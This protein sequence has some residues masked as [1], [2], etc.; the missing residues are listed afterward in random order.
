MSDHL[1]AC[2]FCGQPPQPKEL[3][4][5]GHLI[6]CP[7][8]GAEGPVSDNPRL[9]VQAWNRRAQPV[10]EEAFRALELAN[11]IIFDTI[12]AHGLY[13]DVGNVNAIRDALKAAHRALYPEQY[14]ESA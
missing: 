7:K 9:A 11:A 5:G 10:L 14:G 3:L 1:T 4:G 8:C 12:R 6:A 13:P 2:P